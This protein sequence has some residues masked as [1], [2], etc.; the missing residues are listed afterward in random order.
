M[1]DPNT[2]Q[3]ILDRI[4]AGTHTDD[5]ATLRR[6]LLVD[7]TRQVVQVG[8][9]NVHIGQRQDI[10][11]GDRIY[12]GPDAEAIQQ[13][14]RLMSRLFSTSTARHKSIVSRYV[15][16]SAAKALLYAGTRRFGFA[17]A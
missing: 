1:T 5:L 14:L 9:Y 8:K 3:A 6:Y 7:P 4:A 13:A 10:Q 2:L 11:I 12:Q 16:L 17:S 15:T